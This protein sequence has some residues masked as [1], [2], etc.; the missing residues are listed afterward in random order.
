MPHTEHEDGGNPGP[1]EA[2]GLQ[3][4]DVA[5]LLADHHGNEMTK[6]FDLYFEGSSIGADEIDT[7]S[8]HPI[9][10]GVSSITCVV[11]S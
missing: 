5:A 3:Y 2:D 9:T 10:S 7:F 6:I 4:P 8:P 1:G 11:G